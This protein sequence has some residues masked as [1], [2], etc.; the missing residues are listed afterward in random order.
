MLKGRLHAVGAGAAAAA[1]LMVFAHAAYMEIGF[2]YDYDENG[3]KKNLS[4]SNTAWKE[5]ILK[6]RNNPS[7]C[8]FCI[9][10]EMHNAGRFPEVKAM[11]EEGKALAPGKLIMHDMIKREVFF[12][13]GGRVKRAAARPL[14]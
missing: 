14:L 2:A 4:M 3:K 12:A 13:P 7:V 6:Y 11:Y 10:N 8:I 9:G 5:T 1:D